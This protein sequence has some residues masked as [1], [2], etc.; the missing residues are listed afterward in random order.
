MFIQPKLNILNLQFIVIF[1]TSLSRMALVFLYFPLRPLLC[2]VDYD[3]QLLL[4]YLDIGYGSLL[5]RDI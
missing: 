4:L 1:I 2:L 5:G 3:L